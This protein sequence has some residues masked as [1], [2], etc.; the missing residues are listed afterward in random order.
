M[1]RFSRTLI[2]IALLLLLVVFLYPLI[3]ESASNECL[4]SER[5]L[6]RLALAQS[7][8]PP[9][10]RLIGGLLANAAMGYSKGQVAEAAASQEWP[11]LPP[12]VGCAMLYWDMAIR[13]LPPPHASSTDNSEAQ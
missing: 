9:Q 8:A 7:A 5:I 12:Q 13:G 11:R 2:V 4:A 1:G 10:D 3:G 6:T